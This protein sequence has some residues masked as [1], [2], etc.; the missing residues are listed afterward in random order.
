MQSLSTR[1]HKLQKHFKN[2]SFQE[3]VLQICSFQPIN[4]YKYEKWITI[5]PPT[6]RRWSLLKPQEYIKIVANNNTWKNFDFDKTFFEQLVDYFKECPKIAIRHFE[7]V[8]NC[9]YCEGAWWWAKN[10][11]LSIWVCLDSENVFYSIEVKENCRNVFNSMMVRNWCDS[12]YSSKM[13]FNS[14]K[15]FFSKNI[16]NSNNILFCSNLLWCSECIWC[17]ELQNKSY[18]IWNIQFSKDDYFLKKQ[19]ILNDYSLHSAYINYVKINKVVDYQTASDIWNTQL[20]YKVNNSYNVF[21]SWSAQ[22]NHQ[23]YGVALSWA[24]NLDNCAWI[25]NSGWGSH[26]YCSDYIMNGHNIFYSY[27]LE[28]C[29]FCIWCTWLQNSS[30]CIFNKQYSKEEWAELAEHIFNE[31]ESNGKIGSFFSPQLNPF[32]LN[33]TISV[34]L[35]TT[36]TKDVALQQGYLRRDDHIKVDVPGNIPVISAETLLTEIYSKEDITKV[37]IKDSDWDVYRIMPLEYDFI[38]RHAL[39]LPTSHWTKRMK[40]VFSM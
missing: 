12:V 6:Y 36:I 3:F 2:L 1:H 33:D 8:E 23:L 15:V 17:N 7:P 13:I 10:C 25:I 22:G 28:N 34:L 26:I 19:E 16:I 27:F 37:V 39:T 4:F 11:Y 31:L 14:Y 24:P 9:D 29:S 30:Y 35:D 18:C 38:K 5:Y 20:T 40:E 21:L 32:Y